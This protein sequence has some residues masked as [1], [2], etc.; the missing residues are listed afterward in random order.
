MMGRVSIGMVC[1]LHG[2]ITERHVMLYSCSEGAPRCRIPTWR[3]AGE[4]VLDPPPLDDMQGT[5]ELGWCDELLDPND[6][7]AALLHD[8]YGVL[9]E[10]LRFHDW[11]EINGRAIALHEKIGGY[12]WPDQT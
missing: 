5:W 6:Q 2:E 11:D 9:G 4:V 10:C 8:A 12:L 3:H 1:P 7:V